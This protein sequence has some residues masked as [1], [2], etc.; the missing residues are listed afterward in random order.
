ML[1][2]LYTIAVF[3]IHLI[4]ALRLNFRELDIDEFRLSLLQIKNRTSIFTTEL[5]IIY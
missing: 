3:T 5:Y 1:S 4:S 2:L